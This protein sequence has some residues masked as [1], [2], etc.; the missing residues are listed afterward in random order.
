MCKYDIMKRLLILTGIL[1]LFGSCTFDALVQDPISTLDG[2][3][4]SITDA[5][6]H[7]TGGTVHL[8]ITTDEDWYVYGIPTWLTI[9]KEGAST[10][11]TTSNSGKAGTTKLVLTAKLNTTKTKRACTVYFRT[12][13]GKTRALSVAQDYPYLYLHKEDSH[14]IP[15]LWNECETYNTPTKGVRIISNI[16]WTTQMTN[17]S[18]M[19]SYVLVQDSAKMTTTDVGT[20][21][22]EGDLETWRY[23]AATRNGDTR[24][25]W[26]KCEPMSGNG[27][28]E[29]S[30][31][32]YQYNI[33]EAERKL[34]LRI[35][36]DPKSKLEDIVINFDQPN[37]LFNVDN[38]LMEYQAAY[39][40]EQSVTLNSEVPWVLKKAPFW[41]TVTPM[42]GDAGETNIKL[43]P[44]N[45]NPS[46]QQRTGEIVFR[47]ADVAD[48][49]IT[50]YQHKYIL[51]TAV[52]NRD[53]IENK[54]SSIRE[55][56]IESSGTWELTTPTWI[57]AD[58][59]TG[60]SGTTNVRYFA[61]S[62]NLET[63][64]R[65][66]NISIKSTMNTLI[67][68]IGVAQKKFNFSVSAEKVKLRNSDTRAFALNIVCSG[69]WTVETDVDWLDLSQTTGM[70][71][72]QITYTAD[73]RTDLNDNSERFAK[74][75]VTSILNSLEKEIILC[76]LGNF[77]EVTLL[78]EP[79]FT[80]LAASSKT[81]RI[82]CSAT[83]NLVEAPG[84][85]TIANEDKKGDDNK[86]ISIDASDN[87]DL[88]E[89]NGS[90]VF[91]SDYKGPEKRKTINIT[92]APYI[93]AVESDKT[94][95][96]FPAITSASDAFEVTVRVSDDFTMDYSTDEFSAIFLGENQESDHIVRRYRFTPSDNTALSVRR[97]S[98]SFSSRLGGHTKS[99]STTQAAFEFATSAD[100]FH[101][102][103]LETT[104]R[105]IDI[106]CSSP[107]TL[108]NIPEW[109]HFSKTSGT[110]GTTERITLTVDNNTSRT[111]RSATV[112][113]KSNL[114]HSKNIYV[115]QEG[116]VFN[117]NYSNAV[118]DATGSTG[119]TASIEC[120]GNWTVST[121]EL[122]SWVNAT[123]TQGSGNGNITI[124]L[125][126]NTGT[127]ERSCNVYVKSSNHTE[128]IHI[129]QAAAEK[130]SK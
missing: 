14:Y 76:Q 9:S 19:V 66:G 54:D 55:M 88:K 96:S 37:L 45:P 70:G 21:L 69:P 98:L 73:E 84:W 3:A 124:S 23:F 118:I 43:V 49:Y 90:L 34:E 5:N 10:W 22:K 128:T 85:I 56:Q 44:L 20:L 13:S 35:V 114:G 6:I 2:M 75:T 120:T 117:V 42:S 86:D 130:S 122:P 79:A 129:R 51:N 62:Q 111:A 121:S 108:Q 29:L 104:S 99:I 28:A 46:E 101:F 52:P 107:W 61:N 89:R 31:I 60:D 64:P 18:N 115:S 113:L 58:P 16:D 112:S 102:T 106:T 93:F 65:D 77:F 103:P 81:I 91:E 127:E 40:Q 32:P 80:A 94:T 47:A 36:P 116:Y 126:A 87:T 1:F 59:M 24:L 100:S 4:V 11:L 30:F 33:S 72:T 7:P 83:W 50:V 25:D 26:I 123:P 97:A 15:F 57:T 38:N 53:S 17:T 63:S 105:N 68:E 74:I 12:Q 82:E 39:F 41:M 71:N 8:M 110:G 95:Y 92:Q 67:K 78:E 27:S 125:K 119:I 48:R 109:A